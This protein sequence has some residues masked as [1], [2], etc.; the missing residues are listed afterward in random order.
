MSF[1]RSS[2]YSRWVL[3]GADQQRSFHVSEEHCRLGA[4]VYSTRLSWSSTLSLEFQEAGTEIRLLSGTWFW[5]SLRVKIT[6]NYERLW[7][8]FF[9]TSLWRVCWYGGI[10]VSKNKF[11][12]NRCKKCKWS[13]AC[14][15]TLLVCK[16]RAGNTNGPRKRQGMGAWTWWARHCYW[17]SGRRKPDWRSKLRLL[18]LAG[19]AYSTAPR[20]MGAQTK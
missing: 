18:G 16:S 1:T 7:R 19:F 13:A 4:T 14:W 8:G 9:L 2:R 17:V 11:Q 15:L 6:W 5:T 20:I 3:R 10:L 12:P